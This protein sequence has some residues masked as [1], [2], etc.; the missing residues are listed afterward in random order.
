MARYPTIDMAIVDL[1]TPNYLA[2]ERSIEALKEAESQFYKKRAT[3][4]LSYPGQVNV[5][6]R[7]IE[8]EYDFLLGTQPWTYTDQLVASG[9]TLKTSSSQT[10]FYVQIP[11]ALASRVGNTVNDDDQGSGNEY[12]LYTPG[13]GLQEVDLI[14]GDIGFFSTGSSGT[15]DIGT[16]DDPLLISYQTGFGETP[17]AYNTNST[18]L[19]IAAQSLYVAGSDWDSLVR[20]QYRRY[21]QE[22][23]IYEGS[24]GGGNFEVYRGGTP[25]QPYKDYKPDANNFGYNRPSSL[26]IKIVE[27]ARGYS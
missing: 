25:D 3:E 7:Q 21:K 10:P 19:G 27:E 2:L 23:S 14:F 11:E 16:A 12:V 5:T 9:N 17:V 8:N 15:T 6:E 22:L 18:L 1:T 24:T 26:S 20:E 4:L 13:L